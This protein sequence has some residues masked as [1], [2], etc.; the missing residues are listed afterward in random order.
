MRRP[1]RSDPRSSTKKVEGRA[2]P[3]LNKDEDEKNSKGEKRPNEPTSNKTR[4]HAEKCR[5]KAVS[6]KD[7]PEGKGAAERA[8]YACDVKEGH[9]SGIRA[10]AQ[11]QHPCCNTDG[12]GPT[13]GL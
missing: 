7:D 10:F 11:L 5:R 8:K 9:L 6:G 12:V 13:L 4:D 2:R 1:H 3:L